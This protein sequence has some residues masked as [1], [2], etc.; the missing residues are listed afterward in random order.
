MGE[1]CLASRLFASLSH[2]DCGCIFFKRVCSTPG[3]GGRVLLEPDQ[4]GDVG[5]PG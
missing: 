2:V 3:A 1:V 5:S 4:R